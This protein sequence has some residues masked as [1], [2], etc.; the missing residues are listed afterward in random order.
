MIK[1]GSWVLIERFIN[2]EP[3]SFTSRKLKKFLDDWMIGTLSVMP[4]LGIG[5]H[6]HPN[7]ASEKR[8]LKE[9]IPTYHHNYGNFVSEIHE[10]AKIV[11]EDY[12]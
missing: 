2:P 8:V 10:I 11:S 9:V 4:C 6:H 12:E 5:H 1:A 7:Q 3:P